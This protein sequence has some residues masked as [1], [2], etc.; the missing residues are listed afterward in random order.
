[1]VEL[2]EN[3]LGLSVSFEQSTIRPAWVELSHTDKNLLFPQTVSVRDRMGRVFQY[4]R[5]IICFYLPL[6]ATPEEI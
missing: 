6:D 1:M 3:P 5:Q 4:E 2:C